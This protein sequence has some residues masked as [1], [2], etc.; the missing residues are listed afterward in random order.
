MKIRRHGLQ[1]DLK[2]SSTF[3][4][5]VLA[6]VIM[7]DGMAALVATLDGGSGD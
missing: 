6:V 3:F 4:P 7:V 2:I 1:Y 5:A